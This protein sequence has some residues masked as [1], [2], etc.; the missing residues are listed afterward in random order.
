M[1]AT[2][3]REHELAEQEQEIFK[4]NVEKVRALLV[5][6]G[7]EDLIP[8]LLSDLGDRHITELARHPNG[9]S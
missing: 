6:H 7:A 2:K 9:R 4:A 5:S 3:T 1:K 8:M